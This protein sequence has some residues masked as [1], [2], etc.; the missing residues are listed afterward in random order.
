MRSYFRPCCL[1]TA[2][3]SA[4]NLQPN[5]LYTAYRSAVKRRLICECSIC[6]TSSLYAIYIKLSILFY[7]VKSHNAFYTPRKRSQNT[8][9]HYKYTHTTVSLCKRL[10]VIFLFHKLTNNLK[11]YCS[12]I[13]YYFSNQSNYLNA[14]Y[15]GSLENFWSV[16]WIYRLQFNVFIVIDNTFNERFFT[17]EQNNG[18]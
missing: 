13:L 6:F 4:V 18:N 9:K 8:S 7:A 11:N 14:L 17:V 12:Y 10:A 16:F 1:Y 5:H 15:F 2:Y 3:R